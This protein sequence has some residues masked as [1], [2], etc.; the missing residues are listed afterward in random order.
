MTIYTLHIS[1][2]YL[3]GAHGPRLAGAFIGSPPKRQRILPLQ[4]G[5]AFVVSLKA[6]HQSTREPSP[7]KGHGEGP[8][9]EIIC[10]KAMMQS[11]IEKRLATSCTRPHG[12]P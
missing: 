4:V 5:K 9:K 6:N 1:A 7:N 10:E 8:G 3:L 11:R 2:H 12:G